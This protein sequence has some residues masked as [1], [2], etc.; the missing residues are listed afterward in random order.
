M[1]WYR[2]SYRHSLAARKISTRRCFADIPDKLR[3]YNVYT[4][5]YRNKIGNIEHV[6]DMKPET[7]VQERKVMEERAAQEKLWKRAAQDTD[8]VLPSFRSHLLSAPGISSRKYR[9]MSSDDISTDSKD[10][11]TYININEPQPVDADIHRGEE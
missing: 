4:G 2:D 9:K 3:V 8:N 5:R 7:K 11:V 6:G 1:T 10:P